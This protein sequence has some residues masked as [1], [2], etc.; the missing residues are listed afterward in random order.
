[1]WVCLLHRAQSEIASNDKLFSL[2][3]HISDDL[4][5]L[6]CFSC[7]NQGVSRLGHFSP[8]VERLVRFVSCL[9][10]KVVIEIDLKAGRDSDRA[11]H[12]ERKLAAQLGFV[13]GYFRKRPGG[14]RCCPHI[15]SAVDGFVEVAQSGCVIVGDCLIYGH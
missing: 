15:T 2:V 13:H 5:T 3:C 7:S 14:K 9:A 8:T 4:L 12:V 1:M 11:D 6:D 10:N